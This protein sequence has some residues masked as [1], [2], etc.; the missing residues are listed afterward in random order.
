M[1]FSRLVDLF[2]VFRMTCPQ[3][4][5]LASKSS[6]SKSFC[7]ASPNEHGILR[8]YREGEP[9]RCSGKNVEDVKP[10]CRRA[11]K[12]YRRTSLG[13][14]GFPRSTSGGWPGGCSGKKRKVVLPPSCPTHQRIPRYSTAN[15]FL[16][17][18]RAPLL[19]CVACVCCEGSMIPCR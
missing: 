12:N 9:G 16:N 15:R 10:S 6:V 19:R 17:S 4:A 14:F 7:R 5:N 3:C 18:P 11:K 13:D 2:H 1:C 8:R